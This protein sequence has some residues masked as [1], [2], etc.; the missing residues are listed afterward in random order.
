MAGNIWKS[1][2][3]TFNPFKKGLQDQLSTQREI[4][5]GEIEVDS[6][7]SM[8]PKTLRGGGGGRATEDENIFAVYLA[9]LKIAEYRDKIYDNYS[10]IRSN[11]L[12]Q[13]ILEIMTDDCLRPDKATGNIVNITS[14][15]PEWNKELE[16]LQEKIDFDA[17]IS[18]ITPEILLYGEYAQHLKFEK[19][20][21]ITDMEDVYDIKN[22]LPIYKGGKI[23]QYLVKSETS[24]QQGNVLLPETM[25]GM[26]F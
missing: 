3:Q 7:Y 13:S 21:G 16:R 25:G 17:T 11:Y 5:R 12:V 22:I 14:K 19:G 23:K 15:N 24:E 1:I 9:S 20:L 8:I 10:A 2:F 26:A 6:Y 18:D 4:D